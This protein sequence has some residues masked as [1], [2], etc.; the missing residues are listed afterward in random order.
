[1]S[2]KVFRGELLVASC[3]LCLPLSHYTNI[4]HFPRHTLGSFFFFP[5][6]HSYT[7]KLYLPTDQGGLVCLWYLIFLPLLKNTS[8]SGHTEHCRA[9]PQAGAKSAKPRCC[10]P[11]HIRHKGESG[12]PRG[13]AGK[14]AEGGTS[15][16]LRCSGHLPQWLWINTERDKRCRCNP[17]GNGVS[18]AGAKPQAGPDL[19]PVLQTRRA[20]KRRHFQWPLIASIFNRFSYTFC[21]SAQYLLI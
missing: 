11:V 4:S 8:W 20:G 9:E 15:R 3:L 2:I 1:M 6:S 14:G 21:P 10:S 19:W 17:R 7:V 18:S 13:W 5:P 12:E 16:R